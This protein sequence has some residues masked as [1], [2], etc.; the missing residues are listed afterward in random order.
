MAAWAFVGVVGFGGGCSSKLET[1]YQPRLLGSSAEVRR[2]FYAEPFTVEAA[3]AKK[4]EQEFGTPGG[5][6]NGSRPKPGD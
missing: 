6:S 2:G 4:Y 1:G 5:S 3:K